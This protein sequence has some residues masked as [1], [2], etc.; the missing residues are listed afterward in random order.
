SPST[1]GR[2]SPDQKRRA[3][4]PDRRRSASPGGPRLQLRGDEIAHRLPV[5]GRRAL[6]AS[7]ELGKLRV[8]H[9]R[10]PPRLR[11]V[12]DGQRALVLGGHGAVVAGSAALRLEPLPP[13]P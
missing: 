8:A 4:R 1:G 9:P 7:E 3:R 11:K 2:L 13:P 12:V 6:Q 5:R 10:R